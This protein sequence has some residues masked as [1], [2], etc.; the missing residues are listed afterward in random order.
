MAAE[1]T[2]FDG[3]GGAVGGARRVSAAVRWLGFLAT[4]LAAGLLGASTVTGGSDW[5]AVWASA[6][7]GIAESTPQS[8]SVLALPNA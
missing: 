4:R 8:T 6:N 7:E 1:T 2:G 3:D 5:L